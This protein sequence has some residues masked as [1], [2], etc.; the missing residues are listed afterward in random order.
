M[1]ASYWH[2]KHDRCWER[3]DGALVMIDAATE[4]CTARPWLPNY[5]GWIAYG[6]R[7]NDGWRD[8]LWFTRKGS[9]LHI[10]RKFKTPE[11]AMAAVDHAYPFRFHFCVFGDTH[12]Q[13]R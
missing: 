5:R 12:E 1:T 8:Y 9:L 3:D 13:P 10:P 11:A 7:D 4:C 6:P 2:R